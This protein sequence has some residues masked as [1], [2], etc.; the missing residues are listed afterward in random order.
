MRAAALLLVAA[1]CVGYGQDAAAQI[2]NPRWGLDH[3]VGIADILES[4]SKNK[5][6]VL[7]KWEGGI[8]TGRI[9]LFQDGTT[10][11]VDLDDVMRPINDVIGDPKAWNK[12]LTH[13]WLLIRVRSTSAKEMFRKVEVGMVVDYSYVRKGRLSRVSET[14]VWRGTIPLPKDKKRSYWAY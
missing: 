3:V 9:N 14:H 5:R 10:K 4:Q 7:L 1:A 2:D 8:P 13:G 12:S 6:V 11:Q